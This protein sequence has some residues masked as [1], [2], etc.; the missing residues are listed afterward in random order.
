MIHQKCVLYLTRVAGSCSYTKRCIASLCIR[1]CG[2]RIIVHAQYAP[3]SGAAGCGTFVWSGLRHFGVQ[4]RDNNVAIG[5]LLLILYL[6]FD[7]L[8]STLQERLFRGHAE[9]MTSSNLLLYTSLC[10]ALLSFV[11][12][13]LSQQLAQALAFLHRHPSAWLYIGA[14][15]IAATIVQYSIALII[16]AHRAHPVVPVWHMP[17][18]GLPA[19]RL[20]SVERLLVIARPHAQA[21]VRQQ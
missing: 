1:C 3:W 15:S 5:G 12:L 14:V 7:G 10:S 17:S 13:L 21:G 18:L 16:R 6:A 11:A 9:R 2:P 19:A 4:G 8:T 20:Q